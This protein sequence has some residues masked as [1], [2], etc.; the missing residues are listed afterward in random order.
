MMAR[1][2]IGVSDRLLE[3]RRGSLVE[4]VDGLYVGDVG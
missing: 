3:T 2:L 1:T 4:Q